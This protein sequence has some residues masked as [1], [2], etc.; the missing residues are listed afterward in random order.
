MTGQ[1][2]PTS[3]TTTSQY[4]GLTAEALR[5]E[6]ERLQMLTVGQARLIRQLKQASLDM[7]TDFSGV[8]LAYIDRD[9]A[10]VHTR[11]D[12]IIKKNVI[13]KPKA[14]ACH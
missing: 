9:I 13:I 4:A 3:A 1:T 6:C 7:I 5:S 12:A 8:I 11:L 2:S 14:E 10:A